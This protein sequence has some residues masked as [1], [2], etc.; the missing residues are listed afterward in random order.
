ML[1][2]N[3]Y[4]VFHIGPVPI[5]FWG[6]FVALGMILTFLIIWK[7]GE[8]TGLKIEDVLDLGIYM[9]IGGFVGARLFHVVFYE[10]RYFLVHPFEI[11]NFW[12]GGMSSFGGWFGA[13]FIFYF[14]GRRDKN[15]KDNFLKIADLFSFAFLFGWILGRV[16]C[17]MIHDHLG[18]ISSSI[19]TV[20][21][22]SG[23]RLE[24][25][26]LEILGLLP[27][28]VTFLIFK[29]KKMPDG[30]FM[31]I[32][33]VYYSILR[34]VLDFFRATDIQ[35]A[36]VRYLGLTPGQYFGIL[37]GMAGIFLLKRKDRV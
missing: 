11:L 6:L 34:F 13:G 18:R 14:F 21:T 26:F 23:N 33:F 10:P 35:Q 16:G 9:L 36:D 3:F 31:G 22:A 7:K 17:V 12:E 5:Q 27:L 37:L 28:A 8:K 24:M 30:W 1:F 20:Q 19:F 2:K 29:N 15:I 25:A 32:L 4:T